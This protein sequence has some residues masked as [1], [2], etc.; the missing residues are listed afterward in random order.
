MPVQKRIEDRFT[1][2]RVEDFTYELPK[3]LVAQEP[4]K[5]RDMARLLVVDRSTQAIAHKHFVE[6]PH[7]LTENDVLVINQ[8][9]VFP[10]RL[11]GVKPNGGKVEVLLLS[12]V[13]EGKWEALSKPGLVA[14]TGV[15]FSEKL[16]GVVVEPNNDEGVLTIKFS[17]VGERLKKM[18]E[19]VGLVPLPPYINSTQPQRQLKQDYQTVYANEWG[20]AAAPTAGLHFTQASLKKLADEGVGIVPITLHVGLGTFQPVTNEHLKRKKLHLERFCITRQ[21][22]EQILRAKAHGKRIVAVGTTTARALESA[23]QVVGGKLSLTTEWQE[24]ELLIAPPF[25]FQVVDSLI[26]NF[27]LP[28]SSLLMLVTAFLSRPNTTEELKSFKESLLGKIY[29]L[30]VQERYRFYSFGDAMWIY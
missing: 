17:V 4:V 3:E 5:P 7:I 9:K 16:A 14:G 26:T 24:T 30:A 11:L 6:L 15:K 20:S 28:Q 23:A 13:E 12:E 27:H 25:K 1:N 18:I 21:T 29:E 2:L 22:A 19:E 10:A 8:T